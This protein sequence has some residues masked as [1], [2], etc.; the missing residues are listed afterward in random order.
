MTTPETIAP[1]TL[2]GEVGPLRP[3]GEG[4]ALICFECAREQEATVSS[5]AQRAAA[6][7]RR[8]D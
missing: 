6:Q 1:C 3:Y 4:D 5:I 7:L 8:L 2:C